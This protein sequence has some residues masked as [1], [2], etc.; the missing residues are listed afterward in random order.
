VNPAELAHFSPFFGLAA[1]NVAGH[2]IQYPAGTVAEKPATA[3]SPD[4]TLAKTANVATHN[5]IAL[6]RNNVIIGA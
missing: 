2:P 5:T 3:S 6:H 4:T 1:S